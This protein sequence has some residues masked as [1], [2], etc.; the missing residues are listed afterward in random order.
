MARP[1]VADQLVEDVETLHLNKRGYPASSFQ[2]ALATVIEMSQPAKLEEKQLV[3]LNAYPNDS[4]R[5]VARLHPETLDQLS[6][7]AGDIVQIRGDSTTV[8]TVWEMDGPDAGRGAV[9]IDGFTRENADVDVEDLVDVRPI[10]AEKAKR[11][12]FS[13]PE[14]YE[15]QAGFDRSE[16][17][18]PRESILNQAVQLDDI[19]PVPASTEDPFEQPPGKAVPLE[20]I[21]TEPEGVVLIGEETELHVR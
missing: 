1:H 11:V 19:V 2:E 5:N 20:V 21:K 6:L 9:R 14:T 4:G 12:K 10:Q 18:F 16:W 7:N 8:A 3:V 15:D 17:T 13:S